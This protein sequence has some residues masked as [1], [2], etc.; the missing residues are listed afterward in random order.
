ME[1][2]GIPFWL[3]KKIHD[4]LKKEGP[5]PAPSPSFPCVDAEPQSPRNVSLGFE[6]KEHPRVKP[7]G[8]WTN[9]VLL[10]LHCFQKS[11]ATDMKRWKLETRRYDWNKF[12]A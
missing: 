7:V 2:D 6:G 11:S 8:S 1:L 10:F 9:R 12:D 3:K 5:A 4:A